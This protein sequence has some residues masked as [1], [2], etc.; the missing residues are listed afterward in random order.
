MKS[1][2]VFV[3]ILVTSFAIFGGYAIPKKASAAIT[4]TDLSSVSQKIT[5]S[6]SSV[7]NIDPNYNPQKEYISNI[8]K[9][10]SSAYDQLVSDTNATPSYLEEVSLLKYQ[11]YLQGEFNNVNNSVLIMPKNRSLYLDIL[12]AYKNKANEL[13]TAA[14]IR[15]S[16]ERGIITGGQA[17]SA[18]K[19]ATAN[20]EKTAAEIQKSL[21]K[22]SKCSFGLVGD[23]NLSA[24][25]NE[26]VTWLIKNTL[27]QIAAFL[28][29]LTANMFNYSIQIGVLNFKD[30]APD[31]LYPIWIIV[32][33][34]VSLFIVFAGLYLGFL[35]II[36]DE[37]GKFGRYMTKVVLFALFVNFSYPLAR[38][39]IDVSNI[40][41]LKV[42]ASAVGSQA[43]ISRDF[44]S[45]K[46]AGGLIMDRLGLQGLA[47][48]ATSVTDAEKNGKGMLGEINSIPGALMAVAFT[49]YAAYIFFM[50]TA[51]MVT[52]TAVLVFITIASP[53]LLVDNVIPFLGD[54]AKKLR[55]LFFDQL[56]VGPVF[57]IMLALTLKFLEVFR[58]SSGSG[59]SGM[60]S[61]G[62][63][64]ASIITF[65]NLL[66]ML[67]ML[68]IMIKVTKN[69][70][71]EIGN[72][73]TSKIAGAVG[74]LALG[75][76][77]GGIGLAG[78]QVAGRAVAAAKS[79]GWVSKDPDSISNRFANTL[80]NSS[81]DL[82]NSKVVAKGAG[83]AG[84]GS[85][86]FGVGMGAGHKGGFDEDSKK[87]VE[88]LTTKAKR[89]PTRHER[90]IL[91]K[92]G[93]VVVK[94]GTVNE[95]GVR[96]RNEYLNRGSIFLTKEQKEKMMEE[97]VD[98]DS[99]EMLNT[100]KKQPD[101]ASKTK[102]AQRLRD[103]LAEEKRRNPSLDT[104]EARSLA[105]ALSKIQED[106]KEFEKQVNESVDRYLSLPDERKQLF[107][108]NLAKDLRQEVQA[109]VGAPP[110]VKRKKTPDEEYA[111]MVQE[112]QKKYDDQIKKLSYTIGRGDAQG[113][114]V[115]SQ[116]ELDDIEMKRTQELEALAL[117]QGRAKEQRKPPQQQE[118][119]RGASANDSTPEPSSTP[120]QANQKN[121]ANDSPFEENTTVKRDE[122][123]SPIVDQFGNN[124][125]K[126]QPQKQTTLKGDD[127]ATA[128]GL[129]REAA[130]A[131]K[132]RREEAKAAEAAR[133]VLTKEETVAA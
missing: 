16:A 62:T 90:D 102:E 89:I 85:G 77:T 112:I 23:M 104:V 124:F 106:E 61:P 10:V 70:A 35:Y 120:Y 94:K 115:P 27:L 2:R 44:M 51:I 17:T 59:I 107:L 6:I 43:L 9:S 36:G 56:I 87:K 74:G 3:C 34:I 91:D 69:I 20:S 100:Y 45:F 66:M 49:L 12:S 52:R 8:K 116:K 113:R 24:C 114:H 130:K 86:M 1:L 93:N 40:V 37:E 127:L 129:D 98:E 57:M 125:V 42:Y 122:E 54:N 63:G 121:A 64:G 95:E 11:S 73:A 13:G 79:R 119:K 131:A 46:S 41:S 47:A 88:E 29:W 50:V 97:A 111:D 31:T 75:A 118:E 110:E 28:V 82:R 14:H 80:T 67:I 58:L 108:A 117:Q 7:P 15:V 4:K 21:S 84:F 92:D 126:P 60:A 76:A 78:R 33:Q 72:F 103:E 101:R 133:K 71:G 128:L 99:S 123:V 39:A 65:F 22:N 5:D 53:L 96:A 26:G 18:Q 32:R 30:W 38:T 48:S 55:K 105:R 19:E 68:N 83:M 25:I 81:F 132:A 109:K